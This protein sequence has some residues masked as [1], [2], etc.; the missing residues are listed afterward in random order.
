[1]RPDPQLA[2]STRSRKGSFTGRSLDKRNTAVPSARR[3]SWI[4]RLFMVCVYSMPWARKTSG[5]AVVARSE[6]ASAGVICG[7]SISA[8]RGSPR[9]DCTVMRPSASADA[10]LV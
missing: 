8:R 1:M 6:S 3:C 9:A 2:S 5:A 4:C 7:R 10:S